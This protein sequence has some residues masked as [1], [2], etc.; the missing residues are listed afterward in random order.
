MSQ[1]GYAAYEGMSVSSA[2]DSGWALSSRLQE[3]AAADKAN[4]LAWLQNT[5]A[6]TGS[7]ATA[8]RADPLATAAILR[9]LK[10]E[11]AKNSTARAV[12]SKAARAGSA[13]PAP[14][15]SSSGSRWTGL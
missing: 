14:P 10:E 5:Q 4:L 11:A 15:G 12:A 3:M 1:Q 7:F 8:G 13:R 2:L 6:A 9:G